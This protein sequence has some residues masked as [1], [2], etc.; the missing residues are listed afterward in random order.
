MTL[1]QFLLLLAAGTGAGLVGSTAG[2]ASLVSY[3]ALLLTGLSPITANVTNTVALFGT[4]VGATV[5]ARPELRGQGR[6]AAG[7]LPVMAAGGATGCLLL[8]GLP[9]GSFERVVPFLV[10]LASV[11]LLLQPRVQ[12]LRPGRLSSRNPLALLALFAVGVYGGYFGAAAG[13]VVLALTEV[14]YAQSL[15]RN[16]ALKNVLV[17]G[18]NVVAAVGFALF[19][20]V[21]WGAALAL[22]IGCVLGGRIGPVVV[23]H[24]DPRVLRVAIAVAGLALAVR[25]WAGA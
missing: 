11:L 9:A 10:A 8:L 13:V 12:R 21:A 15:A 18:A 17:G 7:L 25:L 16:N 1:A 6:R 14:L 4:T 3:P 20:D 23:R 22:G 19:A 2:L 5:G 24:L